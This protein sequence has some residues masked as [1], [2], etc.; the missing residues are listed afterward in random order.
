MITKQQSKRN[1]HVRRKDWRRLSV[2]AAE[3]A[4]KKC[5]KR[6]DT[7][8]IMKKQMQPVRLREKRKASARIAAN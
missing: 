2:P 1:R 5:W 8:W 4:S 3:T 7:T 6:L